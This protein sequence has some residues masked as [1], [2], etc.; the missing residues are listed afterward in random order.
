MLVKLRLRYLLQLSVEGICLPLPPPW[1]TYAR[2]VANSFLRSAPLG[3]SARDAARCFTT[4]AAFACNVND[5]LALRRQLPILIWCYRT[6]PPLH[7]LPPLP[8]HSLFAGY[9]PTCRCSYTPQRFPTASA[10]LND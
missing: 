4:R 3:D 8:A 9:Q 5:A 7:L 10:G 1:L 6:L 2:R